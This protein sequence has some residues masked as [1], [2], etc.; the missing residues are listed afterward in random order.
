MITGYPSLDGYM[1]YMYACVCTNASLHVNVHVCRPPTYMYICHVDSTGHVQMLLAD[2][3]SI[4]AEVTIVES[5]LCLGWPAALWRRTSRR[6][7]ASTGPSS[8]G[9]FMNMNMNLQP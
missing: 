5:Q 2:A 7:N 6:W 3:A 1:Y 9:D 8:A 4:V